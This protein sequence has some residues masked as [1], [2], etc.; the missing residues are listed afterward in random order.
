MHYYDHYNIAH[1]QFQ[2]KIQYVF[3]SLKSTDAGLK[4]NKYV[5]AWYC[6]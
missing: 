1:S 3:S 4:Y 6:K 5:A 2:W